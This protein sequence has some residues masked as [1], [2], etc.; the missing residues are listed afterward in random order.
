MFN[1]VKT[2]SYQRVSFIFSL[3]L[4]DYLLSDDAVYMDSED[5][6]QEYV[7]NDVGRMYYGTM[8]QIGVRTWDYGQVKTQ[9][10]TCHILVVLAAHLVL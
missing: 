2:T 8:N 6:R 3:I 5:E 10:N 7:L 9:C 1:K 4:F